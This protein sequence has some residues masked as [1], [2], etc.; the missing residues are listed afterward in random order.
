MKQANN[1]S[2]D[3]FIHIPK[4]GGSSIRTLFTANYLPEKMLSL[5]GSEAEIISNCHLNG[6]T[7]TLQLVQG[8]MPYGVHNHLGM[9]DPRYYFFLREPVARMISDVEHGSRHPSH[10]FHHILSAPELDLNGR[11]KLAVGLT[12][13]QNNMTHFLSGTFFAREVTLTD[14]NLAIDNLWKSEFVGITEQSEVSILIMARKLGWEKVIPQK[15]NVSPQLLPPSYEPEIT[16]LCESILQ[17]DIQLYQVALERFNN[18]TKQYGSELFEAAEQL[19]EIIS[20]Q[21]LDFPESKFKTYMVGQQLEVPLASYLD[22]LDADSPLARW[23]E[24]TKQQ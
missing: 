8:H 11:I 3:F 23:I 14:F 13:Y 9:D 21:E 17:Y 2:T 7:S 19:R 6:S 16:Q 24:A 20:Q 22:A 1:Q 18:L 12:Y 10:G 4:T 5:Y 15:C